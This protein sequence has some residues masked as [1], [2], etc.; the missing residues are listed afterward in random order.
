MDIAKLLNEPEGRINYHVKRLR[1]LFGAHNGVE[2][3]LKAMEAGLIG[4]MDRA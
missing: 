1:G 4:P 3:A 2:V